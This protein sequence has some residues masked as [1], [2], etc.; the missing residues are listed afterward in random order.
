MI[1]FDTNVLVYFSINQDMEK[2]ALADQRIREALSQQKMIISPLVMV[3]YIF[4]LAKLKQIEHQTETVS[5]FQKFVKGA[6]DG[7]S[8]SSPA[9]EYGSTMGQ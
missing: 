2:Q 4:V 3:E 8:I 5:F 9:A 6:L 7:K 1:F